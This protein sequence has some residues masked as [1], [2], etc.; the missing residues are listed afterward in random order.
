MGHT[1][2]SPVVDSCIVEAVDFGAYPCSSYCVA[3][4]SASSGS[5]VDFP[6]FAA[7]DPSSTK[8]GG[9]EL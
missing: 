4:G 9:K 5:L 1:K 6:S 2:L 8:I 7:V 3:V